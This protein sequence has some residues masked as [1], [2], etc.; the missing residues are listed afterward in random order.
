[1]LQYLPECKLH[2]SPRNTRTSINADNVI[3]VRF[4]TLRCFTNSINK[5][6]FV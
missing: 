2:F 6:L 4:Q 1:M 5:F 3:F